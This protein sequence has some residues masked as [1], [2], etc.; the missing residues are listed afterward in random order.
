[1]KGRDK[2]L[3]MEFCIIR[4]FNTDTLYMTIEKVSACPTNVNRNIQQT[5]FFRKAQTFLSDSFVIFQ[6]FSR[7][8]AI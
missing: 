5:G 6:E 8:T 3:K 1:M 7:K 4:A 2:K